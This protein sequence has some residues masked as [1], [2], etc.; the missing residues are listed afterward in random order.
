MRQ[1]H[2]GKSQGLRRGLA[3]PS[4]PMLVPDRSRRPQLCLQTQKYTFSEVPKTL[5]PPHTTLY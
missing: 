2:P 1:G 5:D 3:V 4:S